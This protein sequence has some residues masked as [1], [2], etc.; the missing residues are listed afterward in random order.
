[1]SKLEINYSDTIRKADKIEEASQN[2]T[3]ICKTDIPA[4][5]EHLSANWTGDGGEKFRQ[6]LNKSKNTLISKANSVNS[7][8]QSLEAKAKRYKII[9]DSAKSIFGNLV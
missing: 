3:N 7:I 9:E 2:I 6:K 1:M 5:F 4:V 8:A